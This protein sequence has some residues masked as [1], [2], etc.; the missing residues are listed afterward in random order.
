MSLFYFCWHIVHT[1]RFLCPLIL[2]SSCKS[3]Q[4]LLGFSTLSLS[5]LDA[6][7]MTD[8]SLSVIVN[9][10]LLYS[11]WLTIA[12]GVKH[13]E[14]FWV[15]WHNIF[16]WPISFL[17]SSWL[18]NWHPNYMLGVAIIKKM[19]GTMC[20]VIY[21]GWLSVIRWPYL[22]YFSKICSRGFCLCV[23]EFRGDNF[24]LD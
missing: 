5:N 21:W 16:L 14:W 7:K 20:A 23:L 17:I 4:F 11:F 13:V 22:D 2:S 10:F 3:F 6:E 8:R 18:A 19:Q 9:H 15:C 24:S 12:D 1:S